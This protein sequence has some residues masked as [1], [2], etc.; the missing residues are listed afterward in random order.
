MTLYAITDNQKT[1]Y[2]GSQRSARVTYIYV[3][4]YFAFCHVLTHHKMEAGETR[5]RTHYRV[6]ISSRVV[7]VV[8]VVVVVLLLHHV[9]V[10]DIVND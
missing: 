8:V 9:S 3:A 6:V 1:I 7:V 10:N 5:E 2:T 4:F